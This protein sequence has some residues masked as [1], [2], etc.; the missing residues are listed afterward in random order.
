MIGKPRAGARGASLIAI[1][2]RADL[3][4]QDSLR[5]GLLEEASPLSQTLENRVVHAP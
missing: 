3:S 1:Q 4:E 2:R 5:E